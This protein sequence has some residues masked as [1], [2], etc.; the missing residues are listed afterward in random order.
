MRKFLLFTAMCILGLY[1]NAQDLR[2]V[3][4]GADKNPDASNYDVPAYDYAFYAMSQQIYTAE[5]LG[6]NVGAIYS[7]AFKVGRDTYLQTREYEVYLSSTELDAFDGNNYIALSADD[8]YFDGDV[9]IPAAKD[10]WYTITLDRPFNYLG[11]NFV[12]TI[13]DKT[14]LRASYHSYYKYAAEGRTLCSNQSYDFD[15]MNLTTG[16]AKS[17]VNQLQ[18]G[19][20]ADAKLELSAET[21]ALGKLRVGDFWLEEGSEK[22][23]RVEI[24]A[25]STVVNS[26]T[27]DNDFFT[28]SYDVNANPVVLKVS[29]DKTADVSG[30]QTANIT[31]KANGVADVII[32][33]TAT[34][35][36]PTSS[37]VYELA[38]EITFEE[39][40]F[41]HTPDFANLNDDYNLPKEVKK[42]H[43]P[44]AVYTFELEE[45]A[46]V[47]VNVTG[48]NAIAAIYSE[49]FGGKGG[50]MAKNNNNGILPSAG[51]SFFFNFDD[52]SLAPFTLLDADGDGYKWQLENNAIGDDTYGIASYSYVYTSAG[53][54]TYIGVAPDNYI[55]TK[56]S[57]AI[58]SSSK[59]SYKIKSNGFADK[60]A[61]VVSSDG[62]NFEEVYVETYSA[63]VVKTVEVDLSEYAGNV[64]YIGFRHYDCS[65]QYALFIDDFQLTYGDAKRNAEPQVKAAY[66]AG[67][68]YLVAAAE[69]AF[70]V[71]VTLEVAPPAV[72]TDVVATTINESSI[73][74]SWSAVEDVDAYNIYQDEEF[75]TTVSADVTS[76]TVENLEPSTKYCFIVSSVNNGIESLKTEFACATTDEAPEPEK[77]DAPKN[78]RAYVRQDVPGFNYKY[79]IT[80]AWDAV[81]GATGYDIFV[82]TETAQ[83]FHMG[84]TNG[85]AYVAGSDKEGTLEFY[86]VAFN[87]ET[88]SDPSE[89]YTIVIKDDAIEELNASFNIYPNPVE[90]KLYIEAETEIEEVVVYDIF[91]RH[92][93]AETPSLQG[94]LT[95]DVSDFA[96]GVYFIQIK[97]EEGNITKRFVKE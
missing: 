6:G 31:I 20:A 81:D 93:V 7:I 45:E 87:D 48:K 62:V 60:Y 97:T 83:D 32:P 26:I 55:Y 2:I 27:C 39:A 76:Y 25:V 82:N 72:P 66:P 95:I 38:Q 36:A 88:E 64:L 52:A 51:S 15:M 53:G 79:E 71:N 75:L 42:G 4:V 46:T 33:V 67:K 1:A 11:G 54:G 18:L 14:G 19:M 30:E 58:T 12:L 43:T 68:Y 10:S 44:D 69:D 28:L 90:D 5:D 80:M 96:S 47:E 35:Y 13:Y 78:L 73:A 91:G 57:Y 92:Q 85:T 74:L 49:D 61:V 23:A 77:L 17:Y 21:I 56:E 22:T 24:Q 63:Q 84:Y 37:D 86:V 70:T 16:T 40:S 94:N 34:A 9:E 3:E 50:P 59:M 8:K 29:Y 41:T 65:D 89:P